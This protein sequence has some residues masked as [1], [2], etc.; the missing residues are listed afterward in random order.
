MMPTLLLLAGFSLGI[1]AAA[2][3][4]ALYVHL[5]HPR[6]PK[7][8]PATARQLSRAARAN[9]YRLRDRDDRSY[10]ARWVSPASANF[11]HEETR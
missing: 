3:V 8:P 1:L 5:G 4:V 9:R 7:L 11:D 6:R 10:P 2:T